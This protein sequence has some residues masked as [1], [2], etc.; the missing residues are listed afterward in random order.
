MSVYDR[1]RWRQSIHRAA[2]LPA[3][4]QEVQFEAIAGADGGAA[5]EPVRVKA[6][7]VNQASKSGRPVMSSSVGEAFTLAQ[8]V[9]RATT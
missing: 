5:S 7:I 2:I 1:G 3:A 9:T 6:A 4:E 8:N